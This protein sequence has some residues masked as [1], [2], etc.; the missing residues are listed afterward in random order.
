MSKT[1]G[2]MMGADEALEYAEN[3]I[4]DMLGEVSEE[5][6]EHYERFVNKIRYMVD[7]ARGVA[8]KYHKGKS[9]NNW[10]TCGNCGFGIHEVQYRFC[11]NCGFF[12]T[13]KFPNYK[14]EVANER[15]DQKT[16]DDRE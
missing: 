8:P 3:C 11:P 1:Y 4:P 2:I 16:E 14:N 12:L 9:I 5:T 13:L 6:S 15:S 7:K 10:W